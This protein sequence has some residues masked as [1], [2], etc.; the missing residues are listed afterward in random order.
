[1]HKLNLRCDVFCSSVIPSCLD[2]ILY[3]FHIKFRQR[4]HHFSNIAKTNHGGM[5][6]RH[7]GL[8][9]PTKQFR[10][11]LSDLSVSCRERF[12]SMFTYIMLTVLC[13]SGHE[14]TSHSITDIIVPIRNGCSLRKLTCPG[15]IVSPNISHVSPLTFSV[16][17]VCSVA[18]PG[19]LFDTI[20]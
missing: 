4:C 11:N 16:V 8:C 6:L 3:L 2:C 17:K 20:T 15:P 12:Q 5:H 18:A 13:S 19:Q 9:C 10:N 7:N 14:L 1:M